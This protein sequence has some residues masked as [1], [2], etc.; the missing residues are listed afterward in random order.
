MKGSKEWDAIPQIRRMCFARDSMPR[1]VVLRHEWNTSNSKSEIAVHWDLMLEHEGTLR[2]WSLADPWTPGGM[3]MGIRIPDHRLVYLDYEGPIS[4]DRGQVTC[5]ERGELV[6][7]QQSEDVLTVELWTDAWRGMVE[8]S[9]EK[10]NSSQWRIN[11]PA[12][13][14][15]VK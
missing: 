8:L 1:F 2:T 6:W 12:G 3:A 15:E 14:V 11:W 10:A 4:G 7:R 9:P 13:I 5:C